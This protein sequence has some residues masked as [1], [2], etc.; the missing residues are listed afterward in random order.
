MNKNPPKKLFFCQKPTTTLIWIEIKMKTRS[1]TFKSLW[2]NYKYRF[3]PWIAF[4]LSKEAKKPKEVWNFDLVRI[5]KWH[6]VLSS[7]IRIY[8]F[9]LPF[10]PT[11][12]KITYLLNTYRVSH[13]DMVFFKWLWGVEILRI[14]IIY[15]LLHGPEGYPFVFHQ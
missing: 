7:R 1:K 4:N 3:T 10:L 8:K 12:N 5:C 2:K 14:L 15:L 13:S 11:F 6:L 9:I